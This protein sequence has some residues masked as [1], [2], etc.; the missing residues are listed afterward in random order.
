MYDVLCRLDS[1]T[2]FFAENLMRMLYDRRVHGSFP[3]EMVDLRLSI[4]GW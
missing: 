3:G 4:M 2:L 1:D